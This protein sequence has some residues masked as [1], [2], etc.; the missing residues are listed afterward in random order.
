MSASL[1]V[2]KICERRAADF[3]DS[4]CSAGANGDEGYGYTGPESTPTLTAVGLLCRLTTHAWDTENKRLKKGIEKHIAPNPPDAKNIYYTYYAAQVMFH[5]GGD[6]WK[7]WNDKMRDAL[8]DAQEKKNG[9][10]QGSWP[11]GGPHGATGGRLM[12]TSLSLLTLEVYYRHA[13]Y[14]RLAEGR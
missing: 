3:L 12:Q 8:L 2:P 11:P 10:M 9:P 4:V 13:P 7:K 1:P 6:G 14:F 5:V